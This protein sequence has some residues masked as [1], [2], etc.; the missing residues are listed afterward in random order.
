[1]ANYRIV[2]P[3]GKL[4][5]DVIYQWD[6]VVP[7]SLVDS[8]PA[9]RVVSAEGVFRV[10]DAGEP[11][12]DVALSVVLPISR[13]ELSSAIEDGSRIHGRPYAGE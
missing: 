8:G 6:D 13:E 12:G 1:M 2:D 11:A 7:G 9:L 3:D 10:R 5:N 4:R